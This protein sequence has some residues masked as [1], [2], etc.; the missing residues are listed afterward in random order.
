M[1]LLLF[2]MLMVGAGSDAINYETARYERKLEPVKIEEAI[3]IDGVLNEESWTQAPVAT[4]F[5]QNEPKPGEPAS[6]Q[7]EVRVLYDNENIYLGFFMKESRMDGLVVNE[8]DRDFDTGSADTISVILDTFHDERNG[9]Q[10]STN[11]AGAKYDAQMINEGR[12][13]NA[14]WDGIWYVKTSLESDGWIVEMAIPLKTLKFQ[15]SNVQTWGINF[16]R[17]LRSA[18]R[19][20]DSFWAP[21]PRIYNIKRV[22]LA[23]T[24]ENLEE[25]K[26]GANLKIKPYVLGSLLKT[27][28]LNSNLDG[29]FG[30]D[31]KYG[32]SSGFTLDFTYNTDFSQV[33]ADEQQ[34]NL[35][36]FDLFFP[37]KRDFFLENSGIF[38]F[39]NGGQFSMNNDMVFFFSRRI[40]LSDMG[41]AIPILGGTRLTGRAANW[42]VGFINMQQREFESNPSTNFAV[43]RVRRNILANSDI[44]IMM[45]NKEEAG[46]HYN[47]VL[48]A[49][50]NFRFGQAFSV[51]GYAAKS[52]SPLEGKDSRNM[53]Y[54]AGLNYQDGTYDIN[55]SYTGI[56]EN[57]TNEMGFV[58]R[59]GIR[60][61]WGYAGYNWRPASVRKWIRSLKPHAPLTY[62]VDPE[63]KIETREVGYHTNINF[64]DG[65]SIELGTNRTLENIP[66]PFLISNANNIYVPAGSYNFNSYFIR[67]SSD[68]SRRL[69]G[70]G[71]FEVGDY[72]GG[73]KHTYT[74][75]A[76]YRVNYKLN[77]SL[78][79]THNNISLPQPNG[80]FKTNL[81]LA[82]FNYSFSTTIFL[83][84]LVQYNSDL[85][86][87]SSNIRFNIIH[88][89]LSDFFLVYNEQRDELSGQLLNRAVI[90]KFT[91]MFA[92]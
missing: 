60:K 49:D 62:I 57:F 24:L 34:I 26:P 23:G 9:Y 33:E 44:G 30:A 72:Y 91:Y 74:L 42:E 41:E 90:A 8:L 2:M 39:G 78:N 47:R 53:A 46:P 1:P 86:Q 88:R 28:N 54:K 43:G 25:I 85:R 15:N 31:V 11:A 79:Y 45:T 10:F 82:R 29:D 48:G 32:L 37:E 92:K 13:T 58:P 36:R 65:S 6:E 35:T 80:H 55:A 19:N 56:Q 18:G 76:S 71:R 66:K 52:F 87:W 27:G 73:Y 50:A 7:T 84:A 83:K 67:G 77:A 89:P 22:S 40:G 64:Q 12:A 81:L 70:S 63:G 38:D 69:S 5:I 16:H 20:E 21:L 4:H 3:I 61:F 51:N 75:G 17:N 59:T 68:E 14:D